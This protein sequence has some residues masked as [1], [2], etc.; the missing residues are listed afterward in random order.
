MAKIVWIVT[1]ED[2][3]EYKGAGRFMNTDDY[4]IADVFLSKDSAVK[5]LKEYRDKERA[6]DE[7]SNALSYEYYTP[8]SH[9]YVEYDYRAATY[10]RE[11]TIIEEEAQD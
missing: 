4:S 5:K 1:I 11:F 7:Y 3:K 9:Y 6:T 10:W 2:V 8:D